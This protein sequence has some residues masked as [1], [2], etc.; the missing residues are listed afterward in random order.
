MHLNFEAMKKKFREFKNRI[1]LKINV[2]D[3]KISHM[4]EGLNGLHEALHDFKIE[5]DLFI[6]FA[7]NHSDHGKRIAALERKISN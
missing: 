6:D 5:F 4:Y 3:L 7:S 2:I 1:A